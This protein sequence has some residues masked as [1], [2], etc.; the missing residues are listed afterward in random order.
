MKSILFLVCFLLN[1]GLVFSQESIFDSAR[2]GD[3][4]NLNKAWSINKDTLNSIDKKGFTLL[5][6][7]A[8]YNQTN[9]VE[10]LLKK[11]VDPNFKSSQGT[12]IHGAA[13]KGYF[14]IVKILINYKADVNM[15]DA[16]KST[17]LIYS[18]IF[19]HA[20]IAELLFKNGA[21]INH[22]DGTNQSALEYAISL[23]NEFLINLFQNKNE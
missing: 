17:P 20:D 22:K 23:K 15:M 18:V 12:A 1:I 5:I 9:T 13:Y 6:L 21:D 10:F 8:Y 3:T 14:E 16:N 7:G 2:K 19:G 4:T 11:G